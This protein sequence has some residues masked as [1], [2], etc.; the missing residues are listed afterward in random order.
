MQSNKN[1]KGRAIFSEPKQ[2][3]ERSLKIYSYL[4]C[5][6]YLRNAPN[7][8]GDNVRIFQQRDINLAE[9]KRIFHMDERTIKKCWEGL[10]DERLIKF[11]P[12]GWEEQ[13]YDTTGRE[14]P[15]NDRWK[16]RRKHNETYYEIPI[17]NN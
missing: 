4:V 16:V 9:M 12:H 7:E 11:T 14:I 17:K 8:F 6:A 3:K 13:L 1:V 10:E 15:F 5:K 2:I